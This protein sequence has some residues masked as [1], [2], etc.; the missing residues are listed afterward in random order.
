MR[1][2][3]VAISAFATPTL[4]STATASETVTYCYDA[5]GRLTQVGKLGGPATGK[6]TATAYDPAGNRSNQTTATGSVDCSTSTLLGDS[7]SNSESLTDEHDTPHDREESIGRVDN[8]ENKLDT[9][10]KGRSKS[11]ID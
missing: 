6:K 3:W 9:M 4:P 2:F 7:L 11:Q 5:L 10:E 8:N 1:I